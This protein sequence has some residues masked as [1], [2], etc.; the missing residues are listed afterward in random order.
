MKDGESL[1]ICKY[2][3]AYSSSAKSGK[4]FG[5]THTFNLCTVYLV[6]K[7]FEKEFRVVTDI[8]DFCDY[9]FF[10]LN[11]GSTQIGNGMTIGKMLKVNVYNVLANTQ[12]GEIYL[13]KILNLM[14][15]CKTGETFA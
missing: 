2:R 1:F 6:S 12:T 13:F 5:D 9:I 7:Q 3:H 15:A 10:L 4:Y 11:E 8:C 14:T